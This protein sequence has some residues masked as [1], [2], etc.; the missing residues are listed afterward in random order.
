M[1]RYLC[2]AET[3]LAQLM[4]QQ[5]SCAKQLSVGMHGVLLTVQQ[6]IPSIAYGMAPLH[7]CQLQHYNIAIH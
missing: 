7:A 6:S 3:M 4:R 2:N 1:L 5:P